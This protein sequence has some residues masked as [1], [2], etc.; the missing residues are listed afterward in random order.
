MS[1]PFEATPGDV[2]CERLDA[3]FDDELG[4]LERARVERHLQGCPRCVESLAVYAAL[5]DDLR[6]AH[7]L[8]TCPPEVTAA[9]LAM[10]RAE[11]PA[12][13]PP[14]ES[15]QS[16]LSGLVAALLPAPSWRPALVAGAA[17][18]LLAV[19][20]WRTLRGPEPVPR[21]AALT[22]AELARAERDAR[23]VLGLVA[24]I[25]EDAGSRV[26]DELMNHRIVEPTRRAFGFVTGVP[27]P[28]EPRP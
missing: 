22:P 1:Q 14:R 20:L 13:T 28:T 9:V 3:Y 2:L 21:Q 4:E 10:A 24:A 23:L 15:W 12:A 7:P 19:P 18:V 6:A 8:E 26:K 16:R 11:Q 25:G 27:A 5:R 17:A